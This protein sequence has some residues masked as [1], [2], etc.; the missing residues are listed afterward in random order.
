MLTWLNEIFPENGSHKIALLSRRASGAVYQW[1]G[2][3]GGPSVSNFHPQRG[4]LMCP[5]LPIARSG[6]RLTRTVPHGRN[7][8]GRGQDYVETQGRDA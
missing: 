1:A 4:H 5:P 2:I 7:I 3:N 8:A 6:A